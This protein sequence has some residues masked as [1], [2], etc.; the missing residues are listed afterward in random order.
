MVFRT[1]TSS[2]YAVLTRLAAAAC[3]PPRHLFDL[4]TAYRLLDYMHHGCSVF[5]SQSPSVQTMCEGLRLA[6]L[7]E[8]ESRLSRYFRC[9]LALRH[10]LPAALLAF[11]AAKTAIDAS[12]GAGGPGDLLS[13]EKQKRKELRAVWDVK[14]VHVRLLRPITAEARAQLTASLEHYLTSSNIHHWRL[15]DLGTYR[16]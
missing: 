7:G 14:T 12:I 16:T 15:I 2:T 6:A 4:S 13:R 3:P 9:H 8:T 5:K 1:D 11:L 10:L